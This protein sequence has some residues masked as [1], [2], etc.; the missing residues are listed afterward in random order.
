MATMPRPL[1]ERQAWER[2]RHEELPHQLATLEADLAA[3]L[4]T[5]KVRRET[6]EWQIRRV[7]LRMAE[8]ERR[9]EGTS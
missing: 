3:T 2:E 7:Q 9:L 8:L 4:R 6:L 5:N 1:S